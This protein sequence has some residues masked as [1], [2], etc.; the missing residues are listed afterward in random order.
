MREEARCALVSRLPPWAE[1]LLA[2]LAPAELDALE[3]MRFRCG[4][5]AEFVIGGRGKDMPLVTDGAQMA[6]L[7]AALCGYARY[8]YETQMA[9]GYIPLEG[10]HRAG[11]CGR[12]TREEG[13]KARLCA[14]TS[15]C[16]RVARDVPGASKSVR[17]YLTDG[18][19]SA[20]RALLLGP[21]GCGK[22]TV[23][24][25]AARWLSD[26]R[27]LHVAVAD[28]REELF[29]GGAAGCRIDVL[30]GE[31]KAQAVRTL[32]RAMAPR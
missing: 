10:G 17:G 6:E 27:G 9:Q 32:L 18:R 23:L 25:D 3:E 5:R 22:T 26:A 11:V 31:S 2:A 19:G 8:A 20:L 4:Q 30:S 28:E 1:K 13:G 21:P 29:P 12:L 16:I 24:R 15:V 7:T 14:V